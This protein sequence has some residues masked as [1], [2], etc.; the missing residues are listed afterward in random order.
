M[1]EFVEKI[2]NSKFMQWLQKLS[3]AMAKNDVFSALSGGMGGTMGLIMVGAVVQII[4]AIGN[5]FFGWE[6]TSAI[7]Q[8]VYMPYKLT[9]GM[10]GFFMAFSLAFNYAKKKGQAQLQSG[11][12][13]LVCYVLVMA[14]P[15]SATTDAGSV[16]DALNLSALG[17]GGIFVA[18]IVGFLSVHITKFAVDHNWAIKLPDSVPEGIMNGFNSTIP[19]IINIIIW[20]GLSLGINAA[21]GGAYTL[22]GLINMVL[23]YPLAVLLSPV[24][25][26]VLLCINQIFWFFGIHGTSIIFSVILMPLLGA[27]A[28]NGAA[29]AAGTPL[30]FNAVF[31]Y[32][33]NG[34]LG[35]TGNTLPLTVMGLRSKSKQISA[36]CKAELGPSL[37]GI[38]E[39]MVFGLPLMYNPILL[40][41]FILSPV[42]SALL[43]WGAYALNLIALPQVFIMSC[44]PI[45]LN[46]FMAT[47]DWRNIVFTIVL[48]PVC[49]LIWYPFFKIYEKQCIANEQAAEAAEKAGQQ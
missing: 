29:A 49:W 26:L 33:A 17:T 20:Y 5:V 8:A 1:T 12:V 23:A 31:L 34:R 6:T 13:S 16:I 47:F 42:V 41:P 28:T 11:F 9:M 43:L 22:S 45:F 44:M 32:M 4:C 24:G 35:G 39:P 15:L 38:N 14:P 7:Y 18:M 46:E 21:T 37:F 27:F 3:T 48:F 40:I 25:I 19:T 10:L 36:V 2:A 30:V